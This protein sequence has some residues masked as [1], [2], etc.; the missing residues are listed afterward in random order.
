MTERGG[1]FRHYIF[2]NSRFVGEKD[3]RPLKQDLERLSGSGND[4]EPDRFVSCRQNDIKGF[5]LSR[6]LQRLSQRGSIAIEDL[7]PQAILPSLLQ[8]Q[9]RPEGSRD[10]RLCRILF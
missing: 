10:G 4:S 9:Y 2:D 1:I 5:Y 3:S 8:D 7:R 6:L